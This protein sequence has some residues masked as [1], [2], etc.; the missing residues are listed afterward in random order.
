MIPPLRIKED[1]KRL[2]TL[3]LSILISF[4]LIAATTST[5]DLQLSLKNVSWGIVTI[6]D[7]GGTTT[8][9]DETMIVLDRPNGSDTGKG[10][11]YLN[12]FVIGAKLNIQVVCTAL[13]YTSDSLFEEDKTIDYTVGFEKKSGQGGSFSPSDGIDTSSTKTNSAVASSREDSVE[14]LCTSGT[15]LMTIETKSV[16][17]KRMTDTSKAYY[18]TVKVTLMSV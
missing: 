17:G 10:K 14:T 1:M 4:S 7:E 15:Y 6:E 5:L 2:I 18:G 8:Y 16:K 13:K 11:A 12:F 3:L 9:T